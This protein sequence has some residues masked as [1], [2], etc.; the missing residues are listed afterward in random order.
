MW[1]QDYVPVAGSLLYSTLVAAI[2]LVILFYM[3][4]VRR[5][6]SWI[7][8]LSALGVALVLAVA[9]YGMPVTQAGASMV[10]GAAFGLFPIGW[11][12]IASLILYR[13]TL[14]TGKFEIIKDS[15]GA[16]SD[17]RRLQAVLI[18]FA[19]GA[20]I[21]GAAG[22]GT[23]GRRGGGHVDG[24]RVLPVLC[25]LYLPRRQHRPCPLRLPRDPRRHT[26]WHH[27]TPHGR[28]QFHDGPPVRSDR[29]HHSGVHG[30][31]HVRRQGS[32]RGAARPFSRV[33]SPSPGSCWSSPIRSGRKLPSFWRRSLP[34]WRWSS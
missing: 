22:F 11:I 28:P 25:R 20:F 21:E 10:Y 23:P 33:P 32:S 4:G 13:V 19:F 3:L 14:D 9:V 6:P 12:V 16:L 30:R 29:Y 27:R 2:P 31:H 24:S 18:G 15:I 5:K 7:A 1:E 17:D 34:W 8:G 26:R